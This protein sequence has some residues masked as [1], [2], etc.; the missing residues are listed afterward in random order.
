[1]KRVLCFVL[2]MALLF[3]AC[4]EKSSDTTAPT[5]SEVTETAA[6]IPLGEALEDTE[7][8]FE[9]IIYSED[10][11]NSFGKEKHISMSKE[12]ATINVLGDSIS[13]GSNAGKVYNYSWTSLF[14][15][16]VNDSVGTNNHGF[17]SLLDHNPGVFVNEEIHTITAESGTWNFERPLS[18]VPGFCTYYS[19]SG[20][21]STLLFNIDRRADGFK[22]AING[23]YI[24]YL[25]LPSAGSFDITINGKKITTINTAGD[26]DYFA[27]TAFIQI[28][29]G[30]D[31]KLEIR[32][33]K[34]DAGLVAISGISYAESDSGTTLNNY[35]LPSLALSDIDDD[36]LKG[37]CKSD[38]LIL[39]LGFNDAINNRKLDEF[40]KKLAVISAACRENGTVLVVADFIWQEDKED[41]SIA[42][43][44][45]AA[46]AD[47]YYID[48]RPLA[49]I[50]GTE[51]LTDHAHPDI[52]GHRA[53][54]R[55]ISYFFSVPF[56]SEVK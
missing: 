42:L 19:P 25:Q 31:S 11:V 24:H 55:A 5:S 32:I 34:K 7:K 17:A 12:N 30:L 21:G 26:T 37:L 22:R 52:F 27:K 49:N 8:P 53:I 4:G 35:S 50:S 18:Y 56:C 28:P 14:K 36:T 41:Y 33:A 51:F 29:D 2:L 9:S 47:G 40:K 13:Y 10:I 3:T 44:D 38:Y 23:F 39:S 54:A 1:M 16:S 48:L 45:A 15:Y 46:V 20:T 6:E 43:S